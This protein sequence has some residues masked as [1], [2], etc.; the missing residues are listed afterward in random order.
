MDDSDRWE[1]EDNIEGGGVLS[2]ALQ[3]KYNI[4]TFCIAIKAGGYRL[5]KFEIS[6]SK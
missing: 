6:S 1:I 4:S 5:L 2:I 3:K